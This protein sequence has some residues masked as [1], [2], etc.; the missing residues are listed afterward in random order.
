MFGFIRRWWRSRRRNYL[1]DDCGTFVRQAKQPA[2]VRIELARRGVETPELTKALDQMPALQFKPG[3]SRVV[4]SYPTCEEKR[5]AQKVAALLFERKYREFLSD[6]DG[7][8]IEAR[9]HFGTQTGRTQCK[10]PNI[11]NMPARS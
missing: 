4:L 7:D 6:Y 9:K 2:H 5:N 1:C 10:E 8:P 11:V 3:M